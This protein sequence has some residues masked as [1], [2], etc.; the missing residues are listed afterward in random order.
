MVYPSLWWPSLGAPTGSGWS[1]RFEAKCWAA[2]ESGS[3]ASE[4]CYHLWWVLWWVYGLYIWS[5]WWFH[6][7]LISIIYDNIWVFILPI[8][9]L[10]VF[11]VVIAPPTRYG[12]CTYNIYFSRPRGA[13]VRILRTGFWWLILPSSKLTVGPWKWPIYCGN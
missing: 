6:T 10:T 2:S 4:N 3:S 9:E 8:D 11:K 5:G 1:G 13:P 12:Y 7:F